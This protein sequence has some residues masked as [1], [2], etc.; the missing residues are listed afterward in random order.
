MSKKKIK[1]K[2]KLTEGST[3][4]TISHLSFSL[5]HPCLLS[6][7][8][9]HVLSVCETVDLLPHAKMSFNLVLVLQFLLNLCFGFNLNE[10]D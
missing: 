10:Q 6:H 3:S 8:H 1:E 5:S 4:T 9:G 2:E 7:R